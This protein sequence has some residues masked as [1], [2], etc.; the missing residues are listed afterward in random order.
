MLQRRFASR[1]VQK[2]LA[3]SPDCPQSFVLPEFPIVGDN[4]NT[5][6]ERYRY[7]CAVK[8]I[9]VVS[10]QS[11]QPHG[12]VGADRQHSQ[13]EIED[14]SFEMLPGERCQP[15]VGF[16]GDLNERNG[17]HEAY[18]I[19]IFKEALDPGREHQ[20]RNSPRYINRRCVEQNPQLSNAPGETPQLR[21]RT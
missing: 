10:G 19:R 16:D 3:R 14:Q 21:P 1:R 11:E 12:M 18:G 15:A 9:V 6:G 4:G 5:F 20:I 13:V 8:R 7:Q 17:T 2:P